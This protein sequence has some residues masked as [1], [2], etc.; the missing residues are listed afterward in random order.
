MDECRKDNIYVHLAFDEEEDIAICSYMY[1]HSAQFLP[2]ERIKNFQNVINKY[3]DYL[4]K[5]HI[6]L[7]AMKASVF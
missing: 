4:M 1:D 6:N 7:N 2:Q 3:T 5:V